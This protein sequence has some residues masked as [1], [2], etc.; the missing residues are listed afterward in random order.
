[1]KKVYSS[2]DSLFTHYLRQLLEEQGITCLVK[3]EHLSGA[4]GELPPIECWPEL[5]IFEDGQYQRAHEIVTSVL[6]S[7]LT[8]QVAWTCPA[9]GEELE[10]QFTACWNCQTSRPNHKF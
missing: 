6:S 1:M 3:N 4:A 9:C 8:G 7:G 5:W 2:H 10:A